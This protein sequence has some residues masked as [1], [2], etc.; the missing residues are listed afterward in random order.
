LTVPTTT[1]ILYPAAPLSA[2]ANAAVALR[3]VD[4]LQS[5]PAQ[6]VLAKHG[7]GKP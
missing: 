4:F 5:P 1:P 3:F 6:T 7:F 2:S